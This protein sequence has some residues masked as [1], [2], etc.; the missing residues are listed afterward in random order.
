MRRRDFDGSV[1]GASSTGFTYTR[2]FNT[3]SATTTLLTLNYIS[4]NSTNFNACHGFRMVESNFSRRLSIAVLST[5]VAATGGAVN[6]GGSA[7][8]FDAWGESFATW[9]DPA[10]A[11]GWAIPW[12]VLDPKDAPLGAVAAGYSN[13][14]FTMTVTGGANTVTTDL[15]TTS[16]SATLVYQVD[17]T[18]SIV[19]ITS[20][21]ITTTAGQNTITS[22]LVTG[23]P[24]KVFGVPQANGTIQ[25]YVIF[26]YTGTKSSS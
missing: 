19:T 12:V 8:T 3:A 10:N 17:R 5:F 6:F 13:G 16:G 20:V 26:Y 4:S 15:S 22:N 2:N 21:D 14:A 1:S 7:G 24:V 18:N 11:N 23:T 25:T 9:N